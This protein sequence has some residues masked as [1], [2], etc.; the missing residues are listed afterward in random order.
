MSRL[1]NIIFKKFIKPLLKFLNEGI[2]P[3]KLA[4]TLSIGICFGIIP[5]FGINTLL[6]TII[7]IILRLNLISIQVINYSVYSLQILLYIPFL[8]AGQWLF[9]GPPVYF[10]LTDI[11][12]NFN[13][14]GFKIL[15]ALWHNNLLA[16]I[17]WAI[18]SI[19]LGLLIYYVSKP[20]FEK[21]DFIK[22]E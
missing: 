13:L 11:I 22:R 7:A 3:K 21:F 5:F 9:N 2:T 16:L 17:V 12:N 19:P 1:K 6:L 14:N 10:T 4:L 8:K 15:F 20:V 18:I